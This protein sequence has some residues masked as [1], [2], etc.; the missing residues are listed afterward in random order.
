MVTQR[1]RRSKK[2]TFS[3]VLTPRILAACNNLSDYQ[4]K[5]WDDNLLIIVDKSDIPNYLLQA[6]ID[7]SCIIAKKETCR[8]RPGIDQWP[9]LKENTY[10][11][12]SSQFESI[13]FA[14]CH[15]VAIISGLPG[16]GKTFI[17][18]KLALLMSEALSER[19]Y[20]VLVITKTATTLDTILIEILKTIPGVI[21]FTGKSCHPELLSRQ[22]TRLTHQV[23]LN[24]NQFI[25]HWEQQYVKNQTK[26]N[27]LFQAK[28]QISEHDPEILCTTAPNAYFKRLKGGF[29]LKHK[30][31][32]GSLRLAG[33]KEW[34]VSDNKSRNVA[35]VEKK[36][37][38]IE[39]STI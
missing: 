18:S 30:K 5:E 17:A 6:E 8:A 12:S 9:L 26:L 29:L 19:N 11:L 20:P 7:I 28:S 25:L 27:A 32:Y 38:R 35:I 1:I 2:K 3:A 22:V 21:A 36:S 31:V 15:P 24:H 10:T 39:P 13:R 33:W 16:T 37:Q 4:L 23:D 14:M 34:S